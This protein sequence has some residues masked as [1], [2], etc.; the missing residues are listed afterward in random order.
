[1]RCAAPAPGCPQWTCARCFAATRPAMSCL[2][3]PPG[4][5][6]GACQ[7]VLMSCAPAWAAGRSCQRPAQGAPTPS[8]T[9]L[10]TT[11]RLQQCHRRGTAAGPQPAGAAS[12]CSDPAAPG[13]TI[14]SA[15]AAARSPRS[16]QRGLPLFDHRALLR[17]CPIG[18]AKSWARAR[19]V[20]ARRLQRQRT[21][22]AAPSTRRNAAQASFVRRGPRGGRWRHQ[23]LPR[24]ARRSTSNGRGGRRCT[25]RAPLG[26]RWRVVRSA[27]TATVTLMRRVAGPLRASPLVGCGAPMTSPHSPPQR[28]TGTRAMRASARA[29]LL[30]G[31]PRRAP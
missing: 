27:A 12:R 10:W 11:R 30:R 1:M 28:R 26:A 19:A 25:R 6:R 13:G 14:Q 15:A 17:A 16:R 3:S 20:A 4:C 7:P 23:C 31:D 9:T 5:L 29:T 8:A 21:Q 2:T 18:A 22:A 24:R